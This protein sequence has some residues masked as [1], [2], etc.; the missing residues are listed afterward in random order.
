MWLAKDVLRGCKSQQ[1]VEGSG[2][3][4][5]PNWRTGGAQAA[6]EKQEAGKAPRDGKAHYQDGFRGGF[7]GVGIGVHGTGDQK[8]L[9]FSQI[10]SDLLR[11]DRHR[12][13]VWSMDSHSQFSVT[14]GPCPT[15]PLYIVGT[16]GGEICHRAAP[17][18][19][20]GFEFGVATGFGEGVSE[21]TESWIDGLLD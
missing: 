12:L 3:R 13:F 6:G 7:E 8:I 17:V 10:C 1:D 15:Q 18:V 21:H 16:S 2:K 14:A 11:R 5:A 19:R 9:R 20:E 4:M